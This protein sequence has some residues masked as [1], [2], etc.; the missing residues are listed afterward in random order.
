M[1]FTSRIRLGIR[2]NHVDMSSIY[3]N[4]SAKKMG[5]KLELV[6]EQ[7][8][9]MGLI[10]LEN[11]DL[12][13]KNSQHI[14]RALD[15]PNLIKRLLD[16]LKEA[17]SKECQSIIICSSKVQNPE[18]TEIPHRDTPGFSASHTVTD[19][20][21]AL[22]SAPYPAQPMLLLIFTSI[23]NNGRYYMKGGNEVTTQGA[24][25]Y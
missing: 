22:S 14:S 6:S 5:A 15:S 19:I 4:V 2:H 21:N 16:T 23:Q 8:T 24:A 11:V 10:C 7:G 12:E 18:F 13:S 3:I 9:T 17:R 25:W 20:I 1:L